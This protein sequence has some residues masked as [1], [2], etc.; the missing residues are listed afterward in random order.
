MK[1]KLIALGI[2]SVAILGVVAF[3]TKDAD[4][5]R[6]DYTQVGP[7][8]TEERQARMIEIFENEDSTQ[9]YEDWKA[10]MQEDGRTPGVLNKVETAEEFEIF[11][12]AKELALEGDVEGAA[13][14]RAEI[15]LG[16]GQG[17][18]RRNGDGSGNCNR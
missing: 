10:F 12:E 18:M 16:D 4:A 7:N 8:H 3:G 2:L 14:K 5:Y 6:G 1:N 11:V 15:G 13:Q 9:A 17:Q